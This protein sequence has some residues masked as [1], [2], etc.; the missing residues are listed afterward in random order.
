MIVFVFGSGVVLGEFFVLLLW[1][2]VGWIG[3]FFWI[4]GLFGF[5][6]VVGCVVCL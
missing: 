5:W 3:D 4:E 1:Y 6:W 2:G